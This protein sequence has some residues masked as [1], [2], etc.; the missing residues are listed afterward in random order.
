MQN[1]VLLRI[2][3]RFSLIL[4]NET[5]DMEYLLDV[6]QQELSLA[7][8]AADHLNIPPSLIHSIQELINILSLLIQSALETS[9]NMSDVVTASVGRLG[10]PCLEIHADDLK[11]LLS[12]SLTVEH[13]ARVCGVSRRTLNRR[14]K[15]QGLSVRG[16]YSTM[17]DDELDHVVRSIKS[18]M[19]HAGYRLVKGEGVVS[20]FL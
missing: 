19:P 3:A 9:A 16:C 13:L 12:T 5:L 4:R 11:S 15:E 6:A 17:S 8:M 14:L 7:T 10:R 20:Q 2:Q 18:R 1:E